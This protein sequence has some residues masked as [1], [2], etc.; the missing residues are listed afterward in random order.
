M[1]PAV[2]TADRADLNRAARLIA[3]IS[4]AGPVIA[5]LLH[6]WILRF[7]AIGAIVA[8]L[9][10]LWSTY[11]KRP[12]TQPPAATIPAQTPPPTTDTYLS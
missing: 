6:P 1:T 10:I 2:G 8:A 4:A 3:M 7:P 9:E 5:E 11:A 12:G